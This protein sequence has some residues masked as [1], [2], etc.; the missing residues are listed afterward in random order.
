MRFFRVF[1][2]VGY[3]FSLLL[4]L[5][6][7]FVNKDKDRRSAKNIH[8][9]AGFHLSL[10]LSLSL[11]FHQS[12]A[13]SHLSLLH[14]L[15]F[16]VVWRYILAFINAAPVRSFGV[17]VCALNPKWFECLFMRLLLAVY[18]VGI[19][20]QITYIVVSVHPKLLNWWWLEGQ[21]WYFQQI[22]PT[23]YSFTYGI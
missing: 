5:L 15:L 10:C 3:I 22:F 19:H 20:F 4:S 16:G 11:T 6:S 17:I 13:C 14:Y 7:V 2:I 8:L 1:G 23:M 12:F 9:Y 21:Q 18:D